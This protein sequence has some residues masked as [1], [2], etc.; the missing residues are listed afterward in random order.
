MRKSALLAY[1]AIIL[2]SVSLT[3]CQGFIDAVIGVEDTPT[4]TTPSEEPAVELET[5]VNNGLMDFSVMPGDSFYDY[6]LGTWLKTHE[7]DDNGLMAN[8]ANKNSQELIQAFYDSTDPVVTSLTYLFSSYTEKQALDDV[9]NLLKDAGIS[10]GK[11]IKDSDFDAL[12]REQIL[13]ALV[14]LA[15]AGFAPL[16]NRS[17][18]TKDGVFIKVLTAGAPYSDVIKTLKEEGESDALLEIQG[19]LTR[20]QGDNPELVDNSITKGIL[21]IEKKLAD[22]NNMQYASYL[23]LR[24][25]AN[26]VPPIK[27]SALPASTRGDMSA[28]D[29]IK[30]LNVEEDYVDGKAKSIIDIILTKD[31]KTL[32]YFLCYNIISALNTIIPTDLNKCSEL[33]YKL[34]EKLSSY[35]PEIVNR[36][37]YETLKGK[38]DAEGCQAMMDQMRPLM[39][40]R[41]ANLEWM[42]DATKDAARKK[43]AKMQFNIGMP[44]TK[45]GESLL[46]TGGTVMENVLQLYAQRQK[47]EMALTGK[48]VFKYGWDLYLLGGTI[49]TFNAFYM[50]ALNQLF[51]IPAFISSTFF[52][53]DNEMMCYATSAIFGH[54][55]CHGF[56]A[57]GAKY[58]ENGSLKNWWAPN[59]E[60]KFKE[61]QQ[62]MIERFNELWQYEGVHADGKFT[63]NENMADLGGV[64]LAFELYRKKLTESG[65]SQEKI[66]H[67]LREFFLHHALLWQEDPSLENLQERLTSDEHSTHRNRVIGIDRLMDEWYALFGVIDGTWYIAPDKR[68]KIW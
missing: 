16:L 45:P 63:L 24:R 1:A 60:A 40:Q 43:L 4:S 8:Q 28:A 22:A 46:L 9:L 64:R 44:D 51:I 14:K 6:A 5:F 48:D 13:A 32:G 34:Y 29:V 11:G 7:D 61:L 30:A 23:P 3:S 21:D 49:G 65:L 55:I 67:Q 18:D 41:I 37:D 15:D 10:D 47:A 59:D 52:P 39:D 54:E 31:V 56:D 19:L 20:L 42:S 50:P 62:Q 2:F 53:A 25:L 36:V 58:D 38:F 33:K 35:A 57:L 12:T 27:A 68:V 66:D 17:I 26:P